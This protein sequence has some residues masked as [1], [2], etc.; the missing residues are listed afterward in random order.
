MLLLHAA[1]VAVALLGFFFFLVKQ[2]HKKNPAPCPPPGALRPAMYSPCDW[3]CCTYAP[4]ALLALVVSKL[5]V[6]CVF[7]DSNTRRRPI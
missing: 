6:F 4:D 1:A 2:P 7:L 5:D 3:G